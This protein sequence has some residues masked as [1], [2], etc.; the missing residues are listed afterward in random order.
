[1]QPQEPVTGPTPPSPGVSEPGT[2]PATPVKK[3]RNRRLRLWLA[4]G[5]GVLALLCLGGVGVAVLL[6]D[7]ETKIERAE[8]DAVADS[9]LR[10]YLV[11][12]DDQRA[13]LFQCKS[14]GD[15]QE[16]ANYRADVVSREKKFSV[17]IVITW[18][19]FTV[20][21]TGNQSAVETDLL[22]TASNQS[23]RVTDTWRLNLVDEDGWR[24]CGATQIS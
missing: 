6:Y 7:E 21:T 15:F 5:A 16:I 18:T 9:F 13:T 19:T 3:A 17:G 23:G 8:P 2:T 24:V 10:A 4:L 1:M 20:Q 22:K 11:N 14:G 12:R